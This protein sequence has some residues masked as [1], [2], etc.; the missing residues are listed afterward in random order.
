SLGRINIAAALHGSHIE[1]AVADDGRGLDLAA[2]LEQARRKNIPAPQED[3]D[4]W[5]LLFLPGFSTS[6]IITDLSGRGV[7]L[8]V[9]KSRLESLH[10]TVELFSEPGQGARIVLTV[11]L[12][13][14]TIPALL[15]RAGG[16]TLAFA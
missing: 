6:P 10:G 4:L 2:I 12:T 5:R 14:T 13:L 16:H 11:P 15:V 3:R 7:G 8:D 9:V 1:V